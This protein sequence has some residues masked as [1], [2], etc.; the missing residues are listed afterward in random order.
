MKWEWSKQCP[1][2]TRTWLCVTHFKTALPTVSRVP[3]TPKPFTKD[4]LI[5]HP[6]RVIQ[7]F[8]MYRE[9]QIRMENQEHS[10]HSK[11]VER[12]EIKTKKMP[13]LTVLPGRGNQK[14][15]KYKAP[16]HFSSHKAPTPITSHNKICQTLLCIHPNLFWLLLQC[17]TP[18][19]TLKEAV[20][21]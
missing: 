20:K 15:K 16:F 12:C 21:F 7:I 8:A 13:F 18:Y 10:C 17:E 19:T 4:E 6:I 5:T 9:K 1:C 2:R 14:R 11:I 3:E